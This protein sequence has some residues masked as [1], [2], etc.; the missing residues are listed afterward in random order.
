MMTWRSCCDS[1]LL[2]DHEK[3]LA[4]I[5][6]NDFDCRIIK[7]TEELLRLY[8]TVYNPERV[9]MLWS[10]QLCV[11]VSNLKSEFAVTH[12]LIHNSGEG[13]QHHTSL[14]PVLLPLLCKVWPQIPHRH[15]FEMLQLFVCIHNG[16]RAS[17]DGL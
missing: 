15:V 14:G 10:R 2:G 1:S 9:D 8:I 4:D 17:R 3:Q 5:K 6:V 16:N 13:R 12:H 11:P 7:C